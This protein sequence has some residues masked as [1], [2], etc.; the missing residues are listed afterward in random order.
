MTENQ[1]REWM[2]CFA[3]CAYFI[4]TYIKIYDATLKEW[5]SFTL[6]PEQYRTLKTIHAE[7]LVIIL[8]ARQMGLTWLVLAYILWVVL[9]HPVATALIFS[10]RDDEAVYLVD[11]RLKGMYNRLPGWM[12]EGVTDWIVE[13]D[14]AHQWELSN[15]SNARAFPTNAGDSYTASI[16]LVDEADLV[17]DLDR[18]MRSVKPTIDAGGKLILLSRS[19]KSKPQS[20]FKKIYRAAKQKLTA[21]VAIFLAWHVRPERDQAWYEAQKADIMARTGSLDDL[22]EQYPATDTEALNPRTLDKRIAPKWLNQCYEEMKPIEPPGAPAIPGLVIYRAPEKG[23]EYVIGIDP[24]EGNP[25]S[26]DS[27]AT[28]LDK[29]SGEECAKLKGKFQPSTLSAHCDAVGIWYN[30]ASVLPERNNH[31]HA[32]L[33]WFRDNSALRVLVGTDRRPGWLSSSLGKTT[34]YDTAADVFRDGETIIHSF[35]TFTQLSSIDGSTLRAPEGEMDD[36]ADSYALALV[37]RTRA[38]RPQR[39]PGS[40]QG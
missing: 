24:A 38:R 1:Y 22:H 23:R 13:K 27:A 28:V 30:Q 34:L 12:K 25:T 6:W 31:G 16:A 29:E 7:Q 35:D 18:L 15:G 5:V 4:D 11:E 9:F 14:N 39:Q 26:D 36:L 40:S 19:D 17:P 8:K 20:A 3:S 10:K 21:W 33:L 37:A 32:V 2:K